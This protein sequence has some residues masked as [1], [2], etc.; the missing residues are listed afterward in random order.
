MDKK[1]QSILGEKMLFF[2]IMGIVFAVMAIALVYFIGSFNSNLLKISPKI[3][4]AI[5][6]YRFLNNPECFAYQDGLTGRTDIGLI[7]L[8]RFT[9]KQLDECYDSELSTDSHFLIKLENSGRSVKT[10]G[11]LN[12][13]HDTVIK[14]VRV[15]DN[16]KISDDLMFVYV[17][18]KIG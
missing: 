12:V 13:V 4:D 8:G 10:K 5:F 9:D 11:W 7:D 15:L 6:T 14:K 18:R 1:A 3:N 2:V 16:N 17:Q